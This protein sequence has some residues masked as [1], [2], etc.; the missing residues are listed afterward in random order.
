MTWRSPR[1]RHIV[2]KLMPFTNSMRIYS[3][4]AA[5]S[6]SGEYPYTLGIG[7]PEERSKSIVATSLATA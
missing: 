7:S 4:P 3:V 1:V 5:L 2:L 6:G